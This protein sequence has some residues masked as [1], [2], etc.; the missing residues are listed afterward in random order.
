MNLI[1]VNLQIEEGTI[2]RLKKIAHKE[3]EKIGIFK[4]KYS[5]IIHMAIKKYLEDHE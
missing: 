3:C 2:E 4:I 5:D 1:S